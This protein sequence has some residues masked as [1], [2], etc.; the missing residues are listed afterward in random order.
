MRGVPMFPEINALPR[1][2][3]QPSVAHRN[4]EI[5]GG[6]SSSHMGRHVIGPLNRMDKQPVAIRNQAREKRLQVASDIR[7]GIFLNEQG[8]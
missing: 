8:G 5:D 7:I 2:Q 6:E 4:G 3:R 1:A